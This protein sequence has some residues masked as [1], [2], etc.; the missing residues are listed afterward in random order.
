VAPLRKTIALIV[1]FSKVLD[2]NRAKCHR[3][4]VV[5]L[6]YLLLISHQ[7]VPETK[8][9]RKFQFRIKPSR[10]RSIA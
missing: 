9:A 2:L 7:G 8:W 10:V 5:A 6:A 3:I 4:R 1:G